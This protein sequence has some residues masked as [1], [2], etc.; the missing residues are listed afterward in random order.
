MT[1]FLCSKCHNWDFSYNIISQVNLKQL[2]ASSKLVS[3]L[4]FDS[5]KRFVS[6]R[7]TDIYEFMREYPTLHTDKT[8]LK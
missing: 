6:R 2:V 8:K 3:L 5:V 4:K 7:D 1:V